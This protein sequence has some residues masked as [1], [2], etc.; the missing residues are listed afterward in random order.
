MARMYPSQ[1]LDFHGSEGERLVYRALSRLS[2]D[3]AVFYSYRWLGTLRQRRSEGEAD[4]IVL[5]PTRGILSIEVK[6]GAISYRGGN[7]I[8]RNRNSG[9]EKV[10][11][12]FGQAQES[13]MRI[14]NFLKESNFRPIPLMGRAVWFTSVNFHG[15][16]PLPLEARPEL[17]FD[18]G[19]LENPEKALIRAL[20][21]WSAEVHGKRVALDK[22]QYRELIHTLMP[23]FDLVQTIHST[24]LEVH[25]DFIRLTNKQSAILDFLQEQRVAAIHG[26][27]GT[28]K[29]VLAVEKAR[30]LASG[31]DPVLYLC[32]NEFL[33]D[34]IRK[35]NA[36]AK[37]ISFHNVRTLGE[38]LMGRP[39]AA[40][41]TLASFEDF[42]DRDFDDDS[43]PWKHIVI[44]EGQDLTD[45]M[46]EHLSY[47][48]ELM[49]GCFYV[50]YDRNQQ[51]IRRNERNWIDDHA[52]CRL[53][54]YKNC[55]NTAEIASSVGTVIDM[56][57][58]ENYVNTIHGLA[59]TCAFYGNET[60][61]S[62]LADR[63]VKEMLDNHLQ[64]ED[65][66]I[67]TIHGLPHSLLRNI[68]KVYGIPLSAEPEKGKVWFTNVYRFKGLETKAVLLIDVELSR[69]P[70]QL[71][72]RL[73]YTGASRANT[74]L[75]VGF[76]EDIKKENYPA[77]LKEMGAEGEG[78]E[79][80]ASALGLSM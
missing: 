20:D 24:N 35:V 9:A 18:E 16:V 3:W 31:G 26:A 27:A 21:F 48:A 60:E 77:L 38:A 74:Y 56:R 80:V 62:R 59:P 78:R 63:F 19:D 32:Y 49:D 5:H 73:V 29:T 45:S 54:L 76:Y 12:P 23:S 70:D 6:A 4:F 50:F 57:H 61:L 30:R 75:K 25:T 7:W 11:D 34:H 68:K 66:A 39:L 36:E 79:G 17:V 71:H 69:L 1:V 37:G 42:F 10:I 72:R 13:Q 44:D 22:K 8:Q 43:W 40:G 53:V 28:G 65:I 64:L 67:L 15:N 58:R 14:S 41:E 2:D 52:E 51:V 33:L 47:L 55:R 46:M